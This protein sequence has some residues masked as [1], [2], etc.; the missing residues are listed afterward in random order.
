MTAFLASPSRPCSGG[1][2]T[3]F[4]ATPIISIASPGAAGVF[5]RRLRRIVYAP[6]GRALI[7]IRENVGRM[8]A[9]GLP[10]FIGGW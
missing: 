2:I 8:H 7:G 3:I 9:V 4:T 5:L 6:F 10:V 1:S